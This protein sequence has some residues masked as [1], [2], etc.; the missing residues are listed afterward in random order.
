MFIKVKAQFSI[1][2]P[3]ETR[4]VWINLKHVEAVVA[5]DGGKTY[6]LVFNGGK[7]RTS[8]PK[9]ISSLLRYLDAASLTESEPG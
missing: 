2:D 3:S 4:T 6:D 1:T 7:I 9:S 8:D 5:L